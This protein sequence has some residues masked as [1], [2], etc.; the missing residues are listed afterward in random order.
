[1][2]DISLNKTKISVEH[3][4]LWFGNICAI[5]SLNLKIFEHEIL[6]IIGPANS[7]KT[8]FL[9]TLNRLNELNLRFRMEGKVYIGG[10]DINRIPVN[11]IR[12]RVGMVFALPM[13]LPLSIFDNIA[14]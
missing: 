2:V 9:R 8:S 11:E 5:N 1:M 14:Y 10:E 12:K 6:S 4:H 13:P 3:L 7:G